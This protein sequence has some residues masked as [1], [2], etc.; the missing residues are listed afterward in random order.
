MHIHRRPWMGET[1]S[2]ASAV[3]LPLLVSILLLSSLAWSHAGHDHAAGPTPTLPLDPRAEAHSDTIE[4]VL[5]LEGT[6]LQIYLDDFET[7]EPIV[8]AQVRVEQTTATGPREDL[9]VPDS[10]GL[11]R[12]EAPWLADPGQ[13]DLM[14][15][16]QDERRFDLL[17]ARLEVQPPDTAP[18]PTRILAL[19]PH[20]ATVGVL[21]LVF[22]LGLA[23][24]WLLSRRRRSTRA[25]RQPA[26]PSVASSAADDLARPGSLG[27][28]P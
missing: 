4:M 13:H 21:L 3:R 20:W 17:T 10:A 9:A 7:N 25:A 8:G 15:S 11:Y 27:V 18:A 23:T 1:R 26:Q 14:V 6:S 16:V 22:I 2:W 5:V 19:Q 24:G 28:H 12:L